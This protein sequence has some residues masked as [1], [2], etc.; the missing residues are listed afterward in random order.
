MNK[1]FLKW[2]GGK[3]KIL[4]EVLE[5][6]GEVRGRYFEPFLGSGVVA[7]NVEA[8]RYVLTDVNPDLIN[9]Y[10]QINAYGHRFIHFCEPYFSGRYADEGSY[11]EIRA[12]FNEE[13]DDLKKAIYFVYLNRHAFNGLCRYNA[14][15]YFNVPIGRYKTIYFPEKEIMEFYNRSRKYKIFASTF[16]EALKILDK[17]DVVYCDP[18][19][20]PL[21]D[22]AYFTEYNK[23][24]FGVEQQIKLAEVAEKSNCRFI[25][26][27]HD[28]EFTRELYKN[29]DD[30]KELRVQRTVGA[31]ADSR[32]Q[33]NELLAI[34][35][36]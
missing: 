6:V 34:Y 26:S 19:Y 29:A 4:P 3:R 33:V 7:F 32:K 22:T 36:K 11:Y 18:P 14:K 30:I 24:G 31:S 1:G 9:V 35:N 23:G 2:A 5:A 16:D 21:S 13:N 8:S 17:D 15:G 12:M 10:K 28:L 25:I 20:V 27:N